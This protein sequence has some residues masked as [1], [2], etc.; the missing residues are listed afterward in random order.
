[1]RIATSYLDHMGG[2]Q[3]YYEYTSAGYVG[4][5]VT[6]SFTGTMK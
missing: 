3:I 5:Y 1:M 6:N 4:W 2:Y